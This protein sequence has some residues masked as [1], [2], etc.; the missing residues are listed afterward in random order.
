[1]SNSRF[2]ELV[3]STSATFTFIPK[4]PFAILK[5]PKQ[6]QV[7]MSPKINNQL[8]IAEIRGTHKSEHPLTFYVVKG[9]QYQRRYVVPHQPNSQP[10]LIIRSAYR[11]ASKLFSQI[12]DE[13]RQAWNEYF[14]FVKN[15]LPPGKNY[16]FDKALFVGINTHRILLNLPTLLDPPEPFSAHLDF[17]IS[18]VICFTYSNCLYLTFTPLS[19]FPEGSYFIISVSPPW[20]S[21]TRRTRDN[22]FRWSCPASSLS[23]FI[24]P[25]SEQKLLIP[26]KSY[27][28][29]SNCYID[30][31][32][33]CYTADSHFLLRKHFRVHLSLSPYCY[34]HLNEWIIAP[35][36]DSQSTN[37]LFSYELIAQISNDSSTRLLSY[38]YEFASS[39]PIQPYS[40]IQ[41]ENASNLLFSVRVPLSLYLVPVFSLSANGSLNVFSYIREHYPLIQPTNPSTLEWRPN[42]GGLYIFPPNLNPCFYAIHQE[43]K[44]VLYIYNLIESAL[45]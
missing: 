10:Q 4:T 15:H 36:N 8:P 2:A 5:T 44:K 23:A 22:E 34:N 3:S 37:F 38:A 39:P 27:T 24:I 29:N 30:I 16:L 33:D 41:P 20:L 14:D 19:S 18:D 9:K 11:Q 17:S 43:T 6:L 7:I 42:V 25:P 31:R 13:Q 26:V 35:S 40:L 1:L 45:H 21:K 32:I 12:S 28:Y